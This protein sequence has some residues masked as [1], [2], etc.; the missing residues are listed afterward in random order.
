MRRRLDFISILTRIFYDF[1]AIKYLN[2]LILCPP[3]EPTQSQSHGLPM[4][5]YLLLYFVPLLHRPIN[6]SMLYYL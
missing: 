1:I 2:V 6:R 4:T 3:H 5:P